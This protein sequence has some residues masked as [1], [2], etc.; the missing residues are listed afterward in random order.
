MFAA[1]EQWSSTKSSIFL[2]IRPSIFHSTMQTVKIS[3]KNLYTGVKWLERS[4]LRYLYQKYKLRRGESVG[5]RSN[6]H[7]K[8]GTYPTSNQA[9]KMGPWIVI[10]YQRSR[11]LS[12]ETDEKVEQCV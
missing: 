2:E 8:Y 10:S 3:G 7:K 5:G 1:Q 4:K 12:G 9:L 6:Q 11:C